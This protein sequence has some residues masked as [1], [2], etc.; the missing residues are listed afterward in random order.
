MSDGAPGGVVLIPPVLTVRGSSAA[1][2]AS[3]K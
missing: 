2:P 3:P 1:A